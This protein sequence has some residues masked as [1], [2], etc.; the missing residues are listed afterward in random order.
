MTASH[1]FFRPA[2]LMMA[3]AA[4][5]LALAAAQDS[6]LAA[7]DAY[8]ANDI[9]RLTQIAAAMPADPLQRYPSYW[10]TLKALDHD[11]DAQVARFLAQGDPSLLNERV[12]REWLK[13]LGK[14]QSWSQFESEWNKLPV[15]ARDEETQCYGDLLTLRQGRAPDN[16]DRFLES[17]PLADGCNALI[18]AAAQRGILNQEWLWRRLRLL[19][20]GNF[21][22]QARQLAAANNLAFDATL[23][24]SPARADLA[25]RQGQEATLFAIEMKARTNLPLAAQNLQM[26]E[27]A[28]SKSASGFG[29]GQL[30]LLAARKQQMDDALHWFARADRQQMNNDQWEWWARSALRLGQWDTLQTVIQAMPAPLAAKPAWQYWLGRSLRAQNHAT[31]A[32]QLFAKASLDRGYYGLLSLDEMGTALAAMPDRTAPSDQDNAAIK[33]D[34]AVIRSLELYDIAENAKKP[35]LRVDAQAEWRWSMRGRSDMQ[36]LAASEIARQAGFYDMAIYSAERTKTQHDFSLRYLTPYRDITQRYAQQIGVD[37]AWVYGLIRQESR[38]ITVARSSAGASGLMQLMPSTARWVA[39][40]MGLSNTLA[41]S[42]IDTNIQLGTWYLKYILTSLSSNAVLATAGYNAGPNRARA[43]QGTTPMEGTIYAET[44]PFSETRD[45][46]QKV[47]ANAAYYGTA[48]GNARLT[49]KARMG[50]IPARGGATATP[51]ASP[52]PE[53]TP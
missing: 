37:D 17:R 28:L 34:P 15:D 2:V 31:E 5:T 30:A 44:I 18:N 23:L 21:T 13:K 51:E 48:M 11:D 19:L 35:D 52:A 49:L 10:L 6:L 16:L 47:M 27:G 22:T 38:F 43:W 40:K 50:T 9:P 42:D 26:V 7:L 25:T 36:L 32:N 4:P 1:R 29:W 12:R 3:L 39:K 20:A 46:V 53:V 8:R 45:Y 14:R 24:N 41:V 33:A